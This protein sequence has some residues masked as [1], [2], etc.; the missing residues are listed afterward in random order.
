MVPQ[1]I[2]AHPSSSVRKSI[3]LE[4][5]LNGCG[6]EWLRRKAEEKFSD[7]KSDYELGNKIV[8][9]KWPRYYFRKWGIRN[10]Y[11]C[12]LGADWRLTYALEYDGIGTSV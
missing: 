5:F 9:S 12:K 8:K 1:Y 10:L 7:L 4:A 11:V 2:R 6:N 3:E